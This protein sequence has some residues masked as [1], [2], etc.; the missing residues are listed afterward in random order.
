MSDDTDSPYA[1]DHEQFAAALL[2][3]TKGKP[4]RTTASVLAA[5][6]EVYDTTGMSEPARLTMAREMAAHG[7]TKRHLQVLRSVGQQR[8]AAIDAEAPSEAVHR[9]DGVR[10]TNP[11]EVLAPVATVTSI[12]PADIGDDL[13][14]KLAADFKEYGEAAIIAVRAL[15]P[16]RYLAIIASL[17][18]KEATLNVNTTSSLDSLTLE[19]LS[20][21]ADGL[22]RIAGPSAG[23]GRGGTRQGGDTPEPKS[24]H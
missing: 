18:P 5:L 14:T 24:V 10:A 11:A 2:R 15:D 8:T 12:S 3:I 19:Q 22:A 20:A 17:R 21:L 1:S 9:V 4:L 16:A 23:D 7:E 13:V 6:D